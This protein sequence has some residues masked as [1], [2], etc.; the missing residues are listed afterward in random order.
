MNH[1]ENG[2]LNS[3]DVII[4][5]VYQVQVYTKHCMFDVGIFKVKIIIA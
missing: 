1:N 5:T 4:N 3:A 2:S